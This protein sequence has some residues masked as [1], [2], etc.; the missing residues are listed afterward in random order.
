MLGSMMDLVGRQVSRI[1]PT[2]LAELC[3]LC[4]AG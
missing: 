3:G 2:P 4:F 1:D